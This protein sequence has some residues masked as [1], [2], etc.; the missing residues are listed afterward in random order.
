MRYALLGV[1]SLALAACGGGGAPQ[2]VTPQSIAPPVAKQLS[3]GPLG[4]KQRGIYVSDWKNADVVIF[5]AKTYK[6][7]ST[8]TQGISGPDGEWVDRLGNFYVA[9]IGAG[10][11]A[12]YAPG[13]TT[14]KFTYT[15]GIVN[16]FREVVDKKGNVYGVDG[17]N[18][19]LPSFINMYPQGVDK[20]MRQYKIEGDVSDLT[21]DG[22]GNM[23]VDVDNQG[24]PPSGFLLEFPQGKTKAK[25][26]GVQ[27][28][29]AY[30]M[31]MDPERNLVVGDLNAGAIDII[32]PPYTKIGSQISG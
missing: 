30:S 8:I 24:S 26:L 15:A 2:S 25:Y 23:Y 22:A 16:T 18:G 29:W 13:Q 5:D 12:E 28:G 32:P 14:P 10:D 7:I 17:N 9:N 27:T 20:V 31:V 1:V 4:K 21:F 3:A 6:Q 19:H 11:I